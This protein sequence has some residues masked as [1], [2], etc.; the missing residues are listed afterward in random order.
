MLRVTLLTKRSRT[1]NLLSEVIVVFLTVLN[2]SLKNRPLLLKHSYLKQSGQ[3]HWW[4][5]R[6]VWIAQGDFML[7]QMRRKMQNLFLSTSHSY[8]MLLAIQ[9]A[10]LSTK[11]WRKI[12]HCFLP[13]ALVRTTGWM[14]T[15]PNF[16]ILSPFYILVLYKPFFPANLSERHL[17]PL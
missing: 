6:A 15:S 2:V 14:G 5:I 13:P 4:M 10:K 9:N 11:I 8:E 7:L 3:Q 17:L 1:E 16:F 12:I